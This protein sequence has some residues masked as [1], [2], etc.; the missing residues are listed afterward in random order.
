MSNGLSSKQLCFIVNVI[1]FF[2]GFV[3]SNYIYNFAL[4]NLDNKFSI[5]ELHSDKS[6]RRLQEFNKTIKY[7]HI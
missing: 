5:K 6:A 7:S 2:F 3:Q 4:K 1:Q